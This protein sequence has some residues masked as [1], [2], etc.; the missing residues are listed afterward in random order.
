MERKTADEKSVENE[1]VKTLE[2]ESDTKEPQS[3]THTLHTVWFV[4]DTL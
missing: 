4:K 1:G 3:F 2:L